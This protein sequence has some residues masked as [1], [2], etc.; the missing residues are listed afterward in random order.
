MYW[1]IHV[2]HP[3][4][5]TFTATRYRTR[6]SIY[7]RPKE[8][9]IK[10]QLLAKLKANHQARQCLSNMNQDCVTASPI[11]REEREWRLKQL[12]LSRVTGTWIFH[13]SSD[14]VCRRKKIVSCMSVWTKI[15]HKRNRN[16]SLGTNKQ[17]SF[18]YNEP[19]CFRHCLNYLL[20]A[21]PDWW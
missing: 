17:L 5:K 6:T 1:T 19:V 3:W 13:S 15:F 4:Y 21:G 14:D 8:S 10:V 20:W 16:C 18:L 2:V 12:T 11:Y 7:L 9:W